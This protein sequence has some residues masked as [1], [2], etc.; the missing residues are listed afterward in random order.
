MEVLQFL[1]GKAGWSANT[2]IMLGRGIIAEQHG[3]LSGS[4]PCFLDL[5]RGQ[6]I[7]W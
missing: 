6:L 4:I 7:E 1:A 3:H 2:P 5:L